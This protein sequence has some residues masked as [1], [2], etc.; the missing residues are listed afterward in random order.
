MW[1]GLRSPAPDKPYYIVW[2]SVCSI[3]T[4][5]FSNYLEKWN[6]WSK[7]VFLLILHTVLTHSPQSADG[8]GRRRGH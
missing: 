5:K 7:A 1:W 4:L 8:H 2:G 3:L 6:L